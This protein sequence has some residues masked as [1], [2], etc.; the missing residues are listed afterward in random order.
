MVWRGTC[1][2][3]DERGAMGSRWASSHSRVCVDC[4][5]YRKELKLSM[6]I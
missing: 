5:T 6:G 4:E 2:A 3:P 1:A